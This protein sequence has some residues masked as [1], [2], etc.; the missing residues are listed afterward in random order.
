MSLDP[1]YITDGPLE[2]GFLSKD[3]GLPLAGGTVTFYRDSSR[4]TLK[5]V[6]ELTGAPPNYSYVPLPNPITLSSIGVIQN[7]GG[8]NVVIYYYPWLADGITPDLY[9]VVVKDSNGVDQFTR[10]AWPNSAAGESPGADTSLPVQNQIS[11][12]QFTQIL[13]NDVPTLTPSTTTFSVS[14][15]T[16][17]FE[18]APDWTFIISGTGDVTVER[19]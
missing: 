4:I 19:L 8:D 9:Y 1:R 6:Y 13:I 5:T 15:E 7:A 18:L 12:P 14:A 3:S 10:E 2:E 16:K 17:E 11:N